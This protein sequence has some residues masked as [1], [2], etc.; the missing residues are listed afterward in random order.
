MSNRRFFSEA[1]GVIQH[2]ERGSPNDLWWTHR[3]REILRSGGSAVPSGK[4]WEGQRMRQIA[5]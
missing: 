3:Q 2:V 5:A 4:L 1:W